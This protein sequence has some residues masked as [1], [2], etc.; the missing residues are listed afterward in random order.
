[1]KIKRRI[2]HGMT[3]IYEIFEWIVRLLLVFITLLIAAQVLLRA[4]FS[5]SIPWAEEV[6]LIAF[7]YITFFSLA[8]AM[9]YDIHLRVE[10]GVSWLPRRAKAAIEI[11]DNVLLLGISVMMLWTG[12]QLTRYGMSSIMPS[13]RWS[14]SV[15]YFPTPV[16]G[17][18]CCLQQLL[19]L[20]GISR[21][22]AAEKFIGEANDQ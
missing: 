1:M 15:V 18:M 14:S 13:T 16:A 2:D 12:I 11:I 21:S 3:I 7:V 20:F 17:F 6:S 8:I 19:R 22:E 10:L 9:R 5:Y 4:V